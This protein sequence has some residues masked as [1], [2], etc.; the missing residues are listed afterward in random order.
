MRYCIKKKKYKEAV[1]VI[2]LMAKFNRVQVPEYFTL[3]NIRGPIVEQEANENGTEIVSKRTKLMNWA[4]YWIKLFHTP[5]LWPLITMWFLAS[6]AGTI[7]VFLPLE[8][9]LAYPDVSGAE[10]KVSIGICVGALLGSVIVL[11][12]ALYVNRKTEFKVGLLILSISTVVVTN[13]KNSFSIVFVGLATFA[14]GSSL[15]LHALYTYTPE[16]FPTPI[17]VSCFALCLIAYRLAPI[18]SPFL[19]TYL[20]SIS[21]SLTGIIFA[22]IF[23]LTECVEYFFLHVETFGMPLVEEVMGMP[24][25]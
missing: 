25:V 4:A 1:D 6:F 24:V 2:H 12:V 22:S 15:I 5:W 13:V 10:Y 17:R 16:I 8:L 3:E 9:K 11:Y 7:G 23:V 18:I 21:L 19:V 14:I 20:A